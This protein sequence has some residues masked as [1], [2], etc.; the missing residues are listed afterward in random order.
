MKCQIRD[1]S[2]GGKFSSPPEL[3]EN[4]VPFRVGARIMCAG[5]SGSGKSTFVQNLIKFAREMF[6]VLPVS[7]L[8][9]SHRGSQKLGTEFRAVADAAG[10]PINFVEQIP[11][12]DEQFP[13]HSLLIF[14]DMLTGSDL[15][16]QAA[17]LEPYFTR[18]AHHQ[19]LYVLVTCQNLFSNSRHFR[20]ISSN[21]NYLILFKSFRML[22]QIRHL[23]Q[24]VL[25][26]GNVR[27]L[28]EICKAAT[29]K[30]QYSHILFDWHNLTDNRVRYLSNLFEENGEPCIA[31]QL[32]DF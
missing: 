23:A 6:E 20:Q 16:E 31:Y 13:E 32:T 3:V 7:I 5:V 4:V 2:T 22:H 10:S 25:G 17:R 11:G 9:C 26:A 21:A 30:G 15:N 27:Q 29:G 28:I 12:E 14:D 24:L 8:F 19:K 18:I 1:N